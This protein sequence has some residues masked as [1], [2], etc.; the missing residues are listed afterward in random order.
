MIDQAQVKTPPT[1]RQMLINRFYVHT[2]F[3]RSNYCAFGSGS[4]VHD[5][6]TSAV[7]LG[8]LSSEHWLG[9]VDSQTSEV[10]R[11]Q[12]SL[13]IPCSADTADLAGV[14][15]FTCVVKCLFNCADG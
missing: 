12:S 15:C 9:L 8:P 6:K 2:V 3:T 14:L 4:E 5:L 7:D 13:T 11:T 10:Q 1:V